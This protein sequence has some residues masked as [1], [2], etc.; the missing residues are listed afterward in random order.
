MSSIRN[1]AV[2]TAAYWGF[3][4]T[5]GALR[6]LVLLHF[7]A[8]GYSP[9]ELATLF[10]LYEVCG[11]V[12]NL[13]GGWVG[14][15]LGLNFTLYLGLALQVTALM[16]LSLLD[17][18]WA[19][20][21]SVLYVLLVQGL[22]GVAKDFTKMSA[23][24][25]LKVI[26]PE[27]KEGTLFRWVALLTG[28][29]NTLKGIG[30]F[31]GGFLLSL[32][33]YAMSLYLMAAVLAVILLLCP[34]VLPA[35][36]GRSEAKVKFTAILSKSRDINI[37][38]AARLFLFGARDVWFVVGLP[39]F[40]YDV[41]GFSFTSVGS[42]MAAWVIGYGFVQAG[43]P[44]I[45]RYSN[46]PRGLFW[47]VLLALIPFLMVALSQT[48]LDLTILA[49][50]GLALFGIV[51][52]V[53]S[54]LHSYLILNYSHRDHVALNVGFYYMAN[55]TGRLVGTLLSGLAYGWGGL[56]ACLLTSGAMLL[57]AALF[58][59]F[60]PR[61]NKTPAEKSLSSE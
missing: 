4:L 10:L 56:T 2:V 21:F 33:G 48:G 49:L 44:G 9:L 17:P 7:H 61:S 50:A 54:A 45:L 8:L 23:K 27:E 32:L 1:Y 42:L 41:A 29:K 51:F 36:F 24:S 25:A 53:N 20:D 59:L 39:L 34:F 5:D 28:S 14:Q 60:L 18:L 12:T 55:A 22:A 16:L 11:I 31:L 47:I 30:F 57:I 35:G 26:V 43:A 6:M 58:T 13:T 19:R 3:T 38:S 37:L 15:R 46:D 52:A 40:L